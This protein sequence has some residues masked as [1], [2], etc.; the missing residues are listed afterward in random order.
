MTPFKSFLL[1]CVSFSLS[2]LLLGAVHPST[3]TITPPPLPSQRR[4]ASTAS[5]DATPPPPIDLGFFYSPNPLSSTHRHLLLFYQLVATI[6]MKHNLPF[7]VGQQAESK[8]FLLGFRGAW[9]RC[10]IKE[11][12]KKKGKVAHALEFF[13]FPDEKI[14]WT[15]LYQKSPSDRLSDRTNPMV[16]PSFPPIYQESQR[17]D[18]CKISEVI[19]IVDG[20]WKVGDLVDWYQDGCYWSGRIT[21]ILDED[22]VQVKLPEPPV[23][24]GKSY[25]AS[26]KDLRPS[27][28]W[29]PEH[30]WTVPISKESKICRRCA[31]LIHPMSQ[32]KGRK[33]DI[34]RSESSSEFSSASVSSHGSAGSLLPPELS[35]HSPEREILKQ[36]SGNKSKKKTAI[37]P[38]LSSHCQEREILQQPLGDKNKENKSSSKKR[39]KGNTETPERELLNR[40][41]RDKNKEKPETPELS[42]HSPEREILKKHS[43]DMV[44]KEMTETHM[45]M[46]IETG[47]VEKASFS[48]SVSSTHDKDES[49]ATRKTVACRDRYSSCGSSKKMRTSET[50]LN[51]TCS[52]TI[53]SS[54]LDLEELVNRVKWLKGAIEYGFRFSNAMKPSWKFL[55]TRASFAD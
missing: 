54:I 14:T 10:K 35:S 45:D 25:K 26:C 19:A 49:V 51:S 27:L 40:P 1:F 50:E 15:Q 3:H 18:I 22:N 6:E 44:N 11:I 21:H 4:R 28:D 23:G 37:T 43:G 20:I 48:D 39:N 46:D 30:G 8:S 33:N 24:E 34:G 32:D 13:D 9:F 16:R 7:E 47:G 5:T 36:S 38:V 52:D 2:S 42:L 17:P 53:E 12:G 31:R 29:S 41:S 55:E